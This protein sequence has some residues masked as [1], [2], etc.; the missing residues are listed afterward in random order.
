M[1][2]STRQQNILEAVVAAHIKKAAPVGSK[3]L[4]NQ[5]KLQISPATI[6]HEMSILEQQ[7]LLKQP[8]T[9][10]GR[11]PTDKGYRLY[12]KSLMTGP[13]AHQR[14]QQELARRLARVKYHYRALSRD[15]CEL[16]ADFTE[17]GVLAKSGGQAERSGISNLINL[18]E[19]KNEE[20][21]QAV[22]QVFDK[23]ELFFDKL[24]KINN[25]NVLQLS[26]TGGAPV[27]VY[28]G[29][30]TGLGKYPLSVLVSSFVGR[31][32]ST[33][34]LVLVGPSRMRYRRNVALLSYIAR[35]LSRNG[36]QIIVAIMLPTALFVH[37]IAQ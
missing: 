10:A 2:L 21:A 9:S 7:G 11:V 17:Q 24:Q 12:V 32:G 37:I 26:V 25:K 1:N 18:P 34:H 30:D 36:L 35:L 8:H 13:L 4:L 27:Q 22:A 33:G 3:E 6:R 14:K 23:P 28:I 16:L 5:L 15:L 19:L 29:P 31:D 20:I